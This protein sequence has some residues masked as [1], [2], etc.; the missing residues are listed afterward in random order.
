MLYGGS[1]F[2]KESSQNT[3]CTDVLNT[4]FNADN[5]CTTIEVSSFKSFDLGLY[6]L[7]RATFGTGLDEDNMGKVDDSMTNLLV[8]TYIGFTSLILVNIFIAILTNTVNRVWEKAVAYVILQ[9]AYV[10][11]SQEKGW[12]YA[13]HKNHVNYLH[14]NCCPYIDQKYNETVNN[15]DDKIANLEDEVKEQKNAFK[16]LSSSLDNAVC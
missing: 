11:V 1:Q 13:Q 2:S 7:Y 15:T 14:E 8:G 12:T 4:T 16:E 9:R 5:N 10:I 3:N 6:N